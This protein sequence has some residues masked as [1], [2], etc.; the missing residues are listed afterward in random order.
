MNAGMNRFGRERGLRMYA[1]WTE[2][3]AD[4]ELLAGAAAAVGGRAQTSC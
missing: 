1:D 2:R 4:G 3:I